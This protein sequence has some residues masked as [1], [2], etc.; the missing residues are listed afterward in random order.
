MKIKA[1][2]DH[3]L[4]LEQQTAAVAKAQREYD[5]AAEATKQAHE[6]RVLKKTR[7]WRMQIEQ[8]KLKQEM[9]DTLKQRSRHTS[10]ESEGW[11]EFGV[12][13]KPFKGPKM[14][15][16]EESKDNMDALISGQCIYQLC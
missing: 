1:Q 12:K 9:A 11:M 14:P 4:V 10:A 8:K 7:L 3:E 16:F 5:A 6:L 15:C 13:P 2:Q